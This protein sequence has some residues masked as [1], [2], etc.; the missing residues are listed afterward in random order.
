MESWLLELAESHESSAVRRS[1]IV[2]LRQL[3]STK[4]WPLLISILASEHEN[5]NLRETA[6]KTLGEVG[7]PEVLAILRKIATSGDSARFGQLAARK[8]IVRLESRLRGLSV[9]RPSD[10][11]VGYRDVFICH[12]SENKLEVVR[13]LLA[14]LDAE[15]VSY[16]YDDAEISW[17][18]S[19][20]EKVNQGLKASRFVMAIMTGSFLQKNWPRRELNAV[21]N[22]EAKTG[23]VRVLVLLA[24]S[25]SEN[26]R[27][28][29]EFP[30]I[31]DKVYLEWDGN[32]DSV[33]AALKTRLA[34]ARKSALTTASSVAPVR[35]SAASGALNV[36]E[37]IYFRRELF[38]ARTKCQDAARYLISISE[39]LERMAVSV[40]AGHVPHAELA[41]IRTHARLLTD[42][43]GSSLTLMEA[44]ELVAELERISGA[45][46]LPLLDSPERN[47]FAEDLRSASGT[48]RALG[49]ACA[50]HYVADNQK[51]KAANSGLHQTTAKIK[52]ES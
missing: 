26:R 17:G 45:A 3:G 10:D 43:L 8:A 9:E 15:H 14:A 19:V 39:T 40:T 32:A 37:E 52:G 18:D 12:A 22:L 24:G 38:A 30:L 16:W 36:V 5:Q 28:L 21:L 49:S 25:P 50:I 35:R 47:A 41:A 34:L 48:F 11:D 29:S 23:L 20:T 2:S 33:A 42:A 6:I 31:N 46:T 27:I 13:P 51:T 1:A 4:V 44:D 7:S